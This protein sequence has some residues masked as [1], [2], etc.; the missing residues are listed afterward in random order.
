MPLHLT[1]FK[2][3]DHAWPVIFR[4]SRDDCVAVLQ[5]LLG[6]IGRMHSAQDHCH[7]AFLE[8]GGDLIGARSITGHDRDADH[9]GRILEINVAHGLVLDLDVPVFGRVGG[10]DGKAQ[11]GKPDSL[12]FTGAEVIGVVA[13]IR[14]HQQQLFSLGLRESHELHY[15]TSSIL[16]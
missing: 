5:G 10:D 11:L 14:I 3:G 9:V 15:I 2:I 7:A 16:E 13:G 1:F 4:F 6:A 8:L 12:S